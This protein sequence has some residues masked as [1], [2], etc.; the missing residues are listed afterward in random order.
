[1]VIQLN[2]II[3]EFYM[4][5]HDICASLK[6][7]G[8][9]LPNAG[10][11]AAASAMCAQSGNIVYLSGQLAKRNGKVSLG[12]LGATL[13]TEDGR[14][15]ARSDAIG[16]L[17]TL[18]A[19]LGDLKRMKRIVKMNSLVSSTPEFTDQHLVTNGALE[20]FAD[21]FGESGKHVRSAF[22][23]AQIPLGACGEIELIVEVT[24]DSDRN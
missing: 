20:L 13:T 7:R 24:S 22:G 21:V 4:D 8:S 3:N 1:M 17:A 18:P 9:A 2:L 19:H 6:E 11:P 15:S 14:T 12:K 5:R 10:A 16:L 23:V